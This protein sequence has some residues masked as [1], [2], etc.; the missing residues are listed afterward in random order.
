MKQQSSGIQLRFL[1]QS[2]I[3]ARP[4]IQTTERKLTNDSCFYKLTEFDFSFK[5]NKIRKF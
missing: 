3:R 5:Y 1:K 4:A 2:T